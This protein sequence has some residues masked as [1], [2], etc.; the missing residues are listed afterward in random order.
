MLEMRLRNSH[1]GI[2]GSTARRCEARNSWSTVTASAISAP[3]FQQDGAREP[4]LRGEVHEVPV[5]LL[6]GQQR[7]GTAPGRGDSTP[8]WAVPDAASMV[9]A[10][11][12]MAPRKVRTERRDGW[13]SGCF[14][15]SWWGTAGTRTPS[16]VTWCRSRNAGVAQ[17][18]SGFPRG[19]ADVEEQ[20]HVVQLQ[21]FRRHVRL[22]LVRSVAMGGGVVGR[23]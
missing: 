16:V 2:T 13:D 6:A 18:P 17:R 4:V 10:A 14:T 9:P 20:D 15:G 7:L 8:A 23:C 12:G 1:S 3:L 19:A 21:Q 22:V 11:N 5:E